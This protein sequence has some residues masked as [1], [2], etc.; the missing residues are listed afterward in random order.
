MIYTLLLQAEMQYAF[1]SITSMITIKNYSYTNLNPHV[2]SKSVY[3][4]PLQKGS[5]IIWNN[6]TTITRTTRQIKKPSVKLL[7]Q[8][9]K[10]MEMDYLSYSQ[11]MQKLLHI[12]CNGW[13][14]EKLGI[15]AMAVWVAI[16][17]QDTELWRQWFCQTTT[18]VDI[19]R[20]VNLNRASDFPVGTQNMSKQIYYTCFHMSAVGVW[21]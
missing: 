7:C 4:M 17:R 11:R 6:C 18:K 14:D 15:S 8:S 3:Y 1:K 9:I 2:M 12:W 19:V 20:L 5:R 16:V 10:I 13:L 21:N